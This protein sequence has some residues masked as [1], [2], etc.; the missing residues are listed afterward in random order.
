M[1][2]KMYLTISLLKLSNIVILC[3]T[4]CVYFCVIRTFDVT[5]I[6]CFANNFKTVVNTKNV[7]TK[8]FLIAEE[9]F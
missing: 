8:Q 2:E 4:L 3:V 7:E 5:E 6:I 9:C 1:N